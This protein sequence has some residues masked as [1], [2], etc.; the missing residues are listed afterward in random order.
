MSSSGALKSCIHENP[1]ND[2]EFKSLP[3][4]PR[5]S[6]TELNLTNYVFLLRL[7]TSRKAVLFKTRTMVTYNYLTVAA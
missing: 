7:Q 2:M 3:D 5:H 6:K 4:Q 1:L